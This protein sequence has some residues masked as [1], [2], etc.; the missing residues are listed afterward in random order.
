MEVDD[1]I[2]AAKAREARLTKRVLDV[3][4]GYRAH[5][6]RIADGDAHPEET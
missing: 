1:W 4:R 5:I 3:E 2:G 6:R